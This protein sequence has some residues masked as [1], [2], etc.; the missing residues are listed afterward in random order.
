M[1]PTARSLV[2]S[3]ALF[4]LSGSATFLAAPLPAQDQPDQ[5]AQGDQGNP[6]DRVARL[7]Y[8]G[9]N[10]SLQVN[11]ES[12]WSQASLNYTATTGD[13]LYT[14]QGARA[15]LEIGSLT[16]R[17]SEATDL[18]IANLT[19]QIAQ[20][21]LEQGAIRVRVY[22]LPSGNSVEVDTPNGALT[23]LGPGDYRMDT[24]SNGTRVSVYDGSVQISGGGADQTVDAGA[25]VEL[26]GTGPVQI[27]SVGLPGPDDFDRWCQERDRLV[28][29]SASARYVSRDIPGYSDLDQYGRW[30]PDSEYGP[31]WYPSGVPAGW[32]PYRYG[33]WAWVEPWGWTWVEDEPWGFCPFHYGR[34]AFIGGGWGWVPGPVVV[35]PFYAPALVAFVG[36]SGFS[37]GFG[38][39]GIG[40]AAWF[41]LGPREPF[42][43]SYHYGG[44]YLR[45]VNITNI[46]NVTN[47]T[48]IINV[49]NINNIHYVNR[50]VATTVVPKTVL[51][52]GQPVARQVVK[53]NP[54]QLAR[55][56]IIPHPTIAPTAR[57]AVGAA[58][59][60]PR[61]PVRVHRVIATPG[62]RPAARA[63]TPPAPGRRAA[64]AGQSNARPPLVT[65]MPPPAS[66][67]N[68]RPATGNP[69]PQRATSPGRT[70]PPERAAP[71]QRPAQPQ[72][73]GR[74][75]T[76]PPNLITKRPP[77]P[78][79]VP[80]QAHQ[81]ALQQ[82]PGR[83]LGP[84]QERN[85][86]QGKPAGPPRS[87]EFPPHPAPRA[88]KPAAPSK[89]ESRPP[90]N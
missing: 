47:I 14:D 38:F 52:S 83:P 18:T 10:V 42:F 53:V 15:E 54:Q 67:G 49:T 35:S 5:Q 51:A 16:V 69:P 88:E 39:G 82:D 17:M 63:A 48:N 23:L 2:A 74:P 19:D 70:A 29:D 65:R 27:A 77:P 90:R 26:T 66:S 32:V 22:D 4:V 62:P 40:V 3:L 71:Q 86:Q 1:K 60:V 79:D 72:Q 37:V 45:Q 73:A 87:R 44:D 89:K 31:V 9:G 28:Q 34:W 56:P 57:A 20:F 13:R 7:S 76:T 85:I 24:D 55:A 78:R 25:A 58:K 33:H 12:D 30:Q 75:R 43:P 6:P 8:L 64:P 11:G 59:V 36:G 61:P 84:R 50:T 81:K 80:F 21:G 46:R 41:P 68:A